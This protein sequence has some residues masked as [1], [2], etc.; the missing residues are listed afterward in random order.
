MLRTKKSGFTLIELLVVIAIIAILIALLLPAVQQAREAARRSQ[1]K[2]NLKQLGLGMHNYLD[3]F[4]VFPPGGTFRINEVASGGPFSPQ[5]RILP[6]LEQANLSNLIDF[7]L[8]YGSQTAVSKVRVPVFICP[9]EVEDHMTTNGN[10][11]PITY[12]AN[13]GQWFIW[14][15]T[16]NQQGTG[17]FA[18]NSRFST[19]NFTDG[20]SNTVMMSEVRAFQ[21]FRRPATGSSPATDPGMPSSPNT[22][23]TLGGDYKTSAHTEWVEGRSPQFSFTMTFGPNAKNTSVEAGATVDTD[24][25]SQTEGGSA[26]NPTWAVINTRSM[27]VGLVSTLLADGSVRSMSNNIDLTTWRSLGTRAGGEVVGEF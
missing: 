17:A 24:Y 16:N 26:T 4:T 19:K 15:P 1:C 14:N 13:I 10:H 12:A 23:T 11:W 3:T 8:P 2:N 9:S 25:V 5:A 20:T 22:V 21:P 18:P 7:S 6:Y 27:H